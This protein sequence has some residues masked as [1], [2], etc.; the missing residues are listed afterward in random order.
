MADIEAPDR[1]ESIGP[2][3]FA[4]PHSHYRRWRE[5]GPVRRVRYPDGIVR[6]VILDY[7]A[8]RAALNDPRL[9]K[10]YLATNS[11][12]ADK[13]GL[14]HPDP[15]DLVLFNNMLNIDPPDHTR[16]RKLIMRAF[17]PRRVAELT[18]R[19]EE[20]AAALLDA[21][22]GRDEADLLRD[23]AEPLPITVICELL[24]VPLADRANFQAWTKA[25]VAVAGVE[26]ERESATRAMGDYLTRL[27]REKAERPTADLLSALAVPA[28]D[29]D[30]LT[31]TEQVGMAFLLLVA[32]HDTTVNLIA[33]GTLALL[34][35]PDQW[36]ALRA[37]P[38]LIPTA[39]EEFLRFDGPV[40]I[41][42]IRYTSEP[43][44]IAGVDIP[45]G[46]FVFIALIAANRDEDRYPNPDTLDITRD[47]SGHI[48]FGHGIHFCVG[49]PLAR[50]EARVA[51]SAL[52]SRFP[53]LRLAPRDAALT[54]HPSTL[55]HSLQELPVLLG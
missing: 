19:I 40:N 7:A 18:P 11:L 13:R 14:P 8:G 34:R 42:T 48:A 15:R 53:N 33:N 24:G 41:S 55:I 51:F 23:F 2:D 43:V 29:G 20:I 50:I 1:I 22:D 26:E 47:T 44:T 45:A 12:L 39:V 4:D 31:E 52:L 37:E 9:S 27:V 36:R 3:F 30:A 35:N 6:W 10:N 16:L 32:G 25:L 17:T 54:W 38:E 21:L 46:E 49:A 28:D 5:H